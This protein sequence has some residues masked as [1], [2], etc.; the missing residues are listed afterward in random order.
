M[1]SG[2]GLVHSERPAKELAE[3]GGEFEIIQFWVNAPAKNKMDAPDYQP[4]SKEE[5]PSYLTDDKK[6]ET[7]VVAGEQQN[8]KGKIRPY[9]D[10]LV[11]RMNFKAGGKTT[12]SIPEKYNAFIYQ[13]DGKIR[14]NGEAE[15]ERKSLIWLNRD[16]D[17]IE[18]EALEE[19]RLIL[20][21]GKPIGEAVVSY[22]PFVMNT[23]AQLQQ[24]IIDFQAGKMGE[25]VESFDE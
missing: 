12:Y 3:K 19:S 10:M 2:S 24:A 20:L 13:L 14:I 15:N 17:S 18:I 11:L 1:N 6:V 21:A 16:G 8:I 9:T 4:V 7:F 22:G 5:T 25:L 23:E